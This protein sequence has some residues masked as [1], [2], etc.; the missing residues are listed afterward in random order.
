MCDIHAE[1]RETRE[2]RRGRR[3]AAGPDRDPARQRLRRRRVVP[4]EH[5]EHC[6][7]GIQMRHARSFEMLPYAC[8]LD[9]ALAD[10]DASGDGHRPGKAPAV[11]MEHRQRPEMH[12][13]CIEPH[14]QRHRERLEV[15]AAVVIHDAFRVA[16]RA[17]LRPIRRRGGE[18]R[19]VF[20]VAARSYALQRTA[21]GTADLVRRSLQIAVV[22][23]HRCAGVLDDRRKIARGQARIQ[24]DQHRAREGHTVMAL[25]QYVRVG[26]EHRDAIAR[27]DAERSQ[28]TREPQCA[29][30]ELRVAVALDTVDDRE[31]LGMDRA[32]AQQKSRRRER[33][34][35]QGRVHCG[36]HL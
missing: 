11:A 6:R 4:R 32:R 18:Q 14:V 30:E 20:V 33:L 19:F 21:H 24:R 22:H 2:Q 28:R 9:F 15:R 34:E 29:I 17:D 5:R 27:A 23:E 26:R 25:Q 36:R 8:R 31:A 35:R 3:G 16:G 7:R 12:A 13:G 10:V 1:A